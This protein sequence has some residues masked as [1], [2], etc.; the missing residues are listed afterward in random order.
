MT[1]HHAELDVEEFDDID[2]IDSNDPNYIK[3]FNGTQNAIMTNP[4]ESDKLECTEGV[5]FQLILFD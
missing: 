1:Q 3:H 5:F 4:D 2:D